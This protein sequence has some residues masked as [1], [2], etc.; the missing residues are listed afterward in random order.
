MKI[1]CID[2]G[3]SFTHFGIVEGETALSS[4]TIST[5]KIKNLE[6][7]EAKFFENSSPSTNFDGISFCSVVPE[8]T[9]SL[10]KYLKD[11]YNNVDCFQLTCRNCP[12]ININYP[13]PEE[14]GQDRLANAIAAQFLF[15]VPSIVVD[16]GTAVTFDIV[17]KNGYE[18]GII[19]PGLE[20]MTKYLHEQTALLP[21]LNPDDL[22][23]STGIGKSTIEA[24]NLGCVVGFSG[25]IQA[26][27]DCVLNEMKLVQKDEPTVVATGGSVGA[28]P[29][30][31]VNDIKFY[32]DLTLVGLAESFIRTYA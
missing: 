21:E 25:M 7:T 22:V 20:V 18:G 5:Y 17:S 24:M 3:N 8:V 26:L 28:L 6:N 2:V 29:Q 16:L 1:L 4:Q 31:W 13:K 12:G 23:I 11:F 19:A 27:I 30:Q 9:S 14:I 15:G 10:L 32:P